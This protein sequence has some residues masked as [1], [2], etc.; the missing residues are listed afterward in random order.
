MYSFPD[1]WRSISFWPV[2]ENAVTKVFVSAAI[3]AP[4]RTVW[5]QVRDF[6]SLPEW[7]PK[8]SRSLIE[9]G[10]AGDC[11]G[12]VRSFDMVGGGGTIR[13]RLLELSDIEHKYRYCILASPLP[14]ESYMAELT[15]CPVTVG[16][17]TVGIWTA[18][19]LVVRVGEPD[20]IRAIVDDTFHTGFEALNTL[21]ARPPGSMPDRH[22]A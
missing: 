15:L 18:E 21:L 6:N 22:R 3:D 5:A 8:V 17:R 19:F 13:E 20:A 7:H 11:V 10:L 12:C 2:E 16:N 4:L 1:S 14:V 9:G